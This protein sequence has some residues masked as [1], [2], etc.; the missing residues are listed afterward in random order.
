MANI[1]Y[2]CVVQ[3]P[4]N[5]ITTLGGSPPHGAKNSAVQRNPRHQVVEALVLEDV[6]QLHHIGMFQRL[7]TCNQL[8]RRKAAMSDAWDSHGNSQT[9]C[10]GP[11]KP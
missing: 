11:T 6:E 7:A 9:S 4:I 2:N 10:G 1:T 3:W 5:Q 8:P